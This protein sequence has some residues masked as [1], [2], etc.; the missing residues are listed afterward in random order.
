LDIWHDD[1]IRVGEESKSA[2]RELLTMSKRDVVTYLEEAKKYNLKRKP[3]LSSFGGVGDCEFYLWPELLKLYGDTHSTFNRSKRACDVE[4][5]E[6]EGWESE[7]QRSNQNAEG[8]LRQIS[9]I[10]DPRAEAVTNIVRCYMRHPELWIQSVVS[11]DSTSKAPD[12]NIFKMTSDTFAHIA[13]CSAFS[14]ELDIQETGTIFWIMEIFFECKDFHEK[15]RE[16]GCEEASGEFGEKAPYLPRESDEKTF[17]LLNEEFSNY[18]CLIEVEKLKRK[19]PCLDGRSFK[20][21]LFDTVIA[22]LPLT[23][24]A[25]CLFAMASSPNLGG[26]YGNV[27]FDG[28]GKITNLC[29]GSYFIILFGPSLLWAS[30]FTLTYIYKSV[31]QK[32][33]PIEEKIVGE[34]RDYMEEKYGFSV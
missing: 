33:K 22:P 1:L 6:H 14:R 27:F 10:G 24:L 19:Y 9:G 5:R 26:D 29:I 15:S 21:N 17:V 3:M 28:C 32:N 4:I 20:D 16:E 18:L 25:T 34:A 2:L 7:A 13:F 12:S 11:K 8:F 30:L 23:V 31:K